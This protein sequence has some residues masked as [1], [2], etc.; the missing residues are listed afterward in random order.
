M[1]LD[2]SFLVDLLSG[3]PSAKVCAFELDGTGVPIRVPSP[4]AFEL[5]I[6][7]AQA[8]KPETETGR[9]ERLLQTYEVVAFDTEAARKA[10]F[11]QGRLAARGKPLGTIDAEVVGIALSR[12]ETLVTADKRLLRLG[13]GLRTRE[14][15]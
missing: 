13:S 14:Y 3:D 2:T 15:R 10:G 8:L 12:D 4:A 9:I 6:G 1:L 11:I 7:A 5:W